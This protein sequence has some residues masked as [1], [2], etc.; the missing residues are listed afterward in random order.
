MGASEA[1]PSHVTILETPNVALSCDS[2]LFRD[3]AWTC[4]HPFLLEDNSQE[5]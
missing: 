3:S 5:G 1:E 4:S 2:V